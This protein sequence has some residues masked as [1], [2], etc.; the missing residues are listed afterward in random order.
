MRCLDSVGI[1]SGNNIKSVFKHNRLC[2]MITENGIGMKWP[3]GGLN[4]K[5]RLKRPLLKRSPCVDA[6][7]R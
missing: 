1:L 4:R 6:S 5:A 2:E 3:R 7:V